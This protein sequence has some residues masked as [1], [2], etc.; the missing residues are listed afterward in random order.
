MHLRCKTVTLH[1]ER[2]LK[3]RAAIGLA[4]GTVTIA[5][6]RHLIAEVR[7]IANSALERASRQTEFATT[8]NLF[9]ESPKKV[10]HTL[11]C[12]CT[13]AKRGVERL[14]QTTY[15]DSQQIG[16]EL[17]DILRDLEKIEQHWQLSGEGIRLKLII[18]I[19]NDC[20][21]RVG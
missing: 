12:A 13:S 4:M 18:F 1:D 11:S 5:F 21:V 19:K 14:R 10:L 8:T 3:V 16:V 7:S 9:D 20:K 15:A 6:I 17:S 2:M